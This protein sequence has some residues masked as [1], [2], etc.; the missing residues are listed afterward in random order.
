MFFTSF[1]ETDEEK[2]KRDW[3]KDRNR[4]ERERERERERDG[5]RE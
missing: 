5:G 4:R 3:E 1:S 2:I